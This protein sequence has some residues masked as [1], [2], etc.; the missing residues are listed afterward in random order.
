MTL[1]ISLLGPAEIRRDDQ[2]L[3]LPGYRPLALLAYLLITGKPQSREHLVNLLFDRPDDPRASLRWTLLQI[4]KTI[5]REAIVADRQEIAFNFQSDY[6]LDVSAFE[7]GDLD[8]YRGELLQGLNLRDARQYDA[9]LLVERER[10]RARYQAGLEQRLWELQE[11]EDATAIEETALKLLQLDN[12]R[13]DWHQVLMSAYATQGKF[14][15]G[16]AQ[17]AL[18]RQ[19]LREELGREP[20][21]ETVALARAIERQQAEVY[22]VVAASSPPT[23]SLSES[24][25]QA[26]ME[27]ATPA[28]ME[29]A[30]PSEKGR[31]WPLNRTVIVALAGMI[32][33]ATIV[34]LSVLNDPESPESAVADVA[35]DDES[36]S[37]GDLA[38]TS[39][40]IMGPLQHE[41]LFEESLMPLEKKS[42]IDIELGSYRGDFTQVLPGVIASGLTP[43]IVMFPQ[44]G[45]LAEFVR[46]GQIVDP[47]TFLDEAYLRQQYGDALLDASVLEG[48]MAG[49][50]YSSNVKSLVWYPKQAFDDA[51]YEVPQT[52]DELTALSDQMVADGRTPWCIGL[53]SGAGSGWVGTDWVED[54]LLRTAPLEAYDAWATGELPFD[55]TEIR[56]VFAITEEIWLDESYVYGGPAT[57]VS[58]TFS[59]S[60]RHMFE[61][62]PG[63]FLH[64]Q[65][66]FIVAF[67]PDDAVYGQDYDFFY[68]PPIDA[69]YGRPILG[70]GDIMAMFNDR[71][72]VREVMRYLTTAESVRRLVEEGGVIAPHRDAPFEWYSDPTRLKV[73]QILF[74][75]EAYRFDASDLMPGN[76][77]TGTFRQGII[78][79]VE[80]ADLDSVL[81]EIDDS[82]PGEE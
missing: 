7:A 15:A 4:R 49:V 34:V 39:V 16:Q 18:C 65:A 59:E 75:A 47:R 61:D 51:G 17:Y 52:W 32:L 62:P 79:W 67:F 63:C 73:A 71:P 38:G 22:K 48:Q 56:R 20:T 1:R 2:A 30:T 58:D 66:S 46:Q 41:E 28:P 10:L 29:K 12:L 55:S 44:P 9:W 35:L 54:I 64:R 14:E 19:I 36:P 27:P 74:E 33:L 60:A 82:W 3:D 24:T 45:F 26:E 13:E 70:G 23:L 43:D 50:W 68:L 5:G 72:E 69:E 37:T 25:E 53:E 42:G 76:V 78:D 80:G 6:W 8:Q 31:I 21:S 11:A 40:T 77:G 57:I 81:Q